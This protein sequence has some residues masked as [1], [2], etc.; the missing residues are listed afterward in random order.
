MIQ[1]LQNDLNL[2]ANK[3]KDDEW[4]RDHFRYTYTVWSQRIYNLLNTSITDTE[5]SGVKDSTKKEMKAL[6]DILGK[7]I[8]QN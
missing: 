7:M 6:K 4:K 3:N 5:P 1:K 2:I 8:E